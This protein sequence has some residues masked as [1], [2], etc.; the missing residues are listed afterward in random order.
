[1]TAPIPTDLSHDPGYGAAL[2]ASA[3]LNKVSWISDVSG[4]RTS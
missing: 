1:M 2:S 4:R 3:A